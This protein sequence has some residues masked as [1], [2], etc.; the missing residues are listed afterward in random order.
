MSTS[1]NLFAV[2][3]LGSNS[4]H[5]MVV[6]SINGFPRVISKVKRKVRLASGLDDNNKL[7]LEA[8]QRG[9]DCLA[10]F[11][12]HL[13]TLN[14]NQV[15]VVAT[16]TLR[17]AINADDFCE[18]GNQLLGTPINVISGEQEAALIYH[19]MAVTSN[20]ADKRLIIDIGGA[21]TE[22][23]LGHGLSPIV[24]NSLNMGC[25]TWLDRYFVGGILSQDN[26]DAA[27][28]ASNI[29]LS[30]VK[31]DYLAQQWQLTLG[32][33][34]TMQAVQEVLIAQGYNENVTLDK[35][36]MLMAQCVECRSQDNL[37]IVGLS[38]ER[39]IVFVSGLSILI[40][41][42]RELSIVG[43]LASGGALRE[44][45]IHQLIAISNNRSA[46]SDDVCLQTCESIQQRFQLNINQ[47]DQ[48]V[49]LSE[50]FAHQL[51]LPAVLIPFLK[52]S[53]MIHEL[54]VS[55][56]YINAQKHGHY[57]LKNMPL[58]GFSKQQKNLLISLVG[59]YK[60]KINVAL[61]N[62]QKCCD[63]DQAIQLLFCL[64]LAVISVGRCQEN[65]CIDMSVKK[66]NNDITILVNKALNDNA[67]LL[68]TELHDE[69]KVH[70]E[71]NLLNCHLDIGS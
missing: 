32:A 39:A 42:F 10:L 50:R 34:G 3:D 25:V 12:E 58:A 63:E 48:V 22:L 45:V 1:N 52:L 61:L 49:L 53:A 26:F 20:S 59:N 60:G 66:T 69:V 70:N 51:K 30:P 54:G 17:L 40:S 18:K 62:D 8:M 64:R 35:L 29:V 7:S 47:A 5:M 31:N 16:A 56:N 14:I 36:T 57:V 19:G 24:L 13:S 44:G 6:E 11:G 33:S 27:I 41:L 55:I 71:A 68:V 46:V 4:F 21:S 2:I 23:I 15:R 43:M 67:P 28:E 65:R 38:P 9:W 37:V